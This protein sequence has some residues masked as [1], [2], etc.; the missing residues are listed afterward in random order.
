MI[1]PHLLGPVGPNILLLISW[2]LAIA[3]VTLFAFVDSID[4][5][6]RLCFPGMILYI[7]GVGTVYYVTMVVVV[8]SSPAAD[9]GSVAG[10]FNVSIFPIAWYLVRQ[11]LTSVQ[12]SRANS[13]YRWL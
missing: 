12:E 13:L 4:M 3:G 11:Y 9:Q 1:I 6:W 5:Y 10:I 2:L 8:T 7:A